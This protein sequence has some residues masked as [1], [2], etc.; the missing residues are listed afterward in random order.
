MKRILFLLA[1][2]FPLLALAQTDSKYLEGAIPLD[3]GRVTFT[4]EIKVPGMTQEQVYETI[5][6]WASQRYQPQEKLHARI[7]YSNAEQGNIVAGGEE[8]I[9][10][11][12]SALSLDKSR[13]YYHLNLSCSKETC[14][15]NMTRIRY[16]YEEERKGGEKF[17]AE[18]RITDDIALN[19]NKTKLYPIIGKFRVGTID[20]KDKLINEIQTALNNE[21]I[22]LGLTITS[23]STTKA[24]VER[25]T[26][27]Q[28]RNT[29]SQEKISPAP[30]SQK[31]DLETCISQATRI[32]L[33][34]GNDEQFELG[35]E[36]WG[37]FSELLG[38]KIGY[39][40]IDTQKTMGNQ[41]MAQS[42]QYTIAFYL[43]GNQEPCTIIR[44]KKMMQQQVDGDEAKKL[45]P[46]AQTEKSYYVY[47]GEILK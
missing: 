13:I 28:K 26:P 12:S 35:K 20:L 6:R 16:W 42:E 43:P 7:L 14:L 23:T 40:L 5:L 10:F 2:C 18:E 25:N 19:K 21:M 44:C 33:T 31:T 38:K 22:A 1:I 45:N 27:S 8:Y 46:N 17:T 24:Q 36:S 39:C 29:P 47:I 30:A 11:S 32:T 41:L 9:I 37:G 4:N 3:E 34:A 15:V